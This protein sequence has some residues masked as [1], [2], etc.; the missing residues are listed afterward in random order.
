[1]ANPAKPARHTTHRCFKFIRRQTDD[2]K[3]PD[4]NH[5]DP[6]NK[7]TP[8]NTHNTGVVNSSSR[9]RCMNGQA[10]KPYTP[11][12]FPVHGLLTHGQHPTFSR[13]AGGSR[14]LERP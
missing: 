12:D 3:N 2:L 6:A 14:P 7:A 5:S 10:F 11:S 1:M 8:V 13:P 4:A 9:A